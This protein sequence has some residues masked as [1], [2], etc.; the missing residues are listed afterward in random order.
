MS[1]GIRVFINE[2]GYTLPTGATVRDG[3]EAALPA[4]L[5]SCASG[6]AFVTDARGLPLDLDAPLAAGAIVRAAQRS[7]R[8]PGTAGDA[9]G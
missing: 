5:H 6:D 7:R 1:A 3:I 2:R 9:D 4:L 8:G